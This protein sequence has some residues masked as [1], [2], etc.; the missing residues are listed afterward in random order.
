MLNLFFSI[1]GEVNFHLFRSGVFCFRKKSK[2]VHADQESMNVN[3]TLIEVAM[4]FPF[5][6]GKVK[7]SFSR[8]EFRFFL[9]LVYFVCY[10]EVKLH[11]LT[12]KV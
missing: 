8:F 6:S 7:L 2:F 5:F 10:K 4:F 12:A 3:Q 11:Y 9:S 1:Q